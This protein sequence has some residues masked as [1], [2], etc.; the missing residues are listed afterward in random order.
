[1]TKLFFN[2]KAIVLGAVSSCVAITLV[3]S[4]LSAD[5]LYCFQLASCHGAA[6]C[7]SGGS[8]D[9]MCNITCTGGGWVQCAS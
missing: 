6:G 7:A 8:L 9:S 4:T 3:A 1:M 5:G 2:L